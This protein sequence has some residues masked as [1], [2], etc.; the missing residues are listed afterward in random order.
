[1]TS[2]FDSFT[3]DEDRFSLLGE[4]LYHVNSGNTGGVVSVALDGTSLGVP[5]ELTIQT[6]DGQ[7]IKDRAT[8]FRLH[9]R[10]PPFLWRNAIPHRLGT[11][12][13]ISCELFPDGASE[14][15]MKYRSKSG[16]FA[17]CYLYSHGSA[18]VPLME[19]RDFTSH[20]HE[21]LQAILHHTS[22]TPKISSSLQKIGELHLCGVEAPA[23]HIFARLNQIV[24]LGGAC[25]V[26]RNFVSLFALRTSF[27]FF[28]K[29]RFTFP[30]GIS[31]IGDS[32]FLHVPDGLG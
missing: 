4:V 21:C 24:E 27:G 32:E 10:F 16:A 1:M 14:S 20:F 9:R 5:Y 15:V 30:T 25:S 8:C 31:K 7:R 11:L 3:H 6:E 2:Y 17:D 28:N 19:S 12:S 22:E 18:A 29:V 13:L 26:P 23:S